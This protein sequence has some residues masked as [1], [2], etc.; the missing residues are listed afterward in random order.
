MT[1]LLPTRPL[2]PRPC[3]RPRRVLRPRQLAVPATLPSANTTPGWPHPCTPAMRTAFESLDQVHLQTVLQQKYVGFQSP[4]AF[5]KCR[6]R[7]AL[8]L[9]PACCCTGPPAPEHYPSR[10][11]SEDRYPENKFL[12]SA[13]F[14]TVSSRTHAGFLRVGTARVDGGEVGGWPVGEGGRVGADGAAL[15]RRNVVPRS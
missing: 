14:S 12:L 1:M 9:A 7:Q 6:I 5:L 2:T 10:E 4:P 11:T 15:P 3:P 13:P 8:A